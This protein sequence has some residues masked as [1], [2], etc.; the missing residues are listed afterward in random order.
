MDVERD[1]RGGH[2][3]G[4][5]AS[6]AAG[7]TRDQR[8]RGCSCG[9]ST[10]QPAG[11]ACRFST[12]SASVPFAFGSP[13]CPVV[14]KIATRVIAWPRNAA[15]IPPVTP[16]SQPPDEADGERRHEHVPRP[17][18]RPEARRQPVERA[19]GSRF[20]RFGSTPASTSKPKTMPRNSASSTNAVAMALSTRPGI[21]HRRREADAVVAVEGDADRDRGP[22]GAVGETEDDGSEAFAQ[23]EEQVLLRGRV[24]QQH[25]QDHADADRVPGQPAEQ[26]RRA[27]PA[28]HVVVLGGAE[29]LR[30]E[31]QDDQQAG[32]PD[33]DQDAQR[34][35]DE[36]DVRAARTGRRSG[37]GRAS[38]GAD[39]AHQPS[40]MRRIARKAS[41]GISTDPTRFIRCF[42]SFCF[43]SSFRLRVMSPP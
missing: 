5:A 15:P 26:G 13:A 12:S 1:R 3:V 14:M 27:A 33:G 19:P 18:R 8:S 39:G 35:R 25:Q 36:R 4:A 37:M 11:V 23:A 42:P 30:I 34:I 31:P 9:P 17:A 38:A 21:R 24:D 2:G 7:R 32:Q 41:C 16:V 28:V 22:D 40:S 43:S 6:G 10:R 29:A 20:A